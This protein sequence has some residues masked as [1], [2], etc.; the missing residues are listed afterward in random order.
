MAPKKMIAAQQKNR[1]H[2][3]RMKIYWDS[4]YLLIRNGTN[5][6]HAYITNAIEFYLTFWIKLLYKNSALKMQV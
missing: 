6:L 4:F 2:I 5:S 1:T 3:R